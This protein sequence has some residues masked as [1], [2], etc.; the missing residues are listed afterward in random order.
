MNDINVKIKSSLYVKTYKDW[1]LHE[2]QNNY[3]KL[4]YF[5]DSG[6]GF[7]VNGQNITAKD[8]L[9]LYSYPGLK[10]SAYSNVS[11]Y[12][13]YY[14][15]HFYVYK[16]TYGNNNSL[17]IN[18]IKEPLNIDTALQSI[19]KTDFLHRFSSIYDIWRYKKPNYE[20]TLNTLLRK[21]LNRLLQQ[22]EYCKNP[23]N[24]VASIQNTLDYISAHFVEDI[25]LDDLITISG[26]SKSYFHKVFKEIT[27]YTVSHYIRILRID[28]AK[29]YLI[30]TDLSIKDIALLV[31]Y[32][33]EFYFSRVFKQL[34]GISPSKYK[35]IF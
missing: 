24:T 10:H 3:H 8:G 4:I 13:S 9:L 1:G 2:R 32:E 34:E 25:S 17:N 6:G 22:Q 26:L 16:V 30:N 33:D 27:G 14:S 35:T 7:N 12:M 5:T 29:E 20:F 21:L 19:N 11:E 15:I 31:G 23:T 18:E 28:S